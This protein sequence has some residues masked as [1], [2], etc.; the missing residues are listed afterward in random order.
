[1]LICQILHLHWLGSILH[2]NPMGLVD[3]QQLGHRNLTSVCS[4]QTQL[5]LC[6]LCLV[7]PLSVDSNVISSKRLPWPFKNCILY[8]IVL[9][10][11]PLLRLDFSTQRYHLRTH[12]YFM[13]ILF[14]A[15]FFSEHDSI[16]IQC[17]LGP[18]YSMTSCRMDICC[19]IWIQGLSR[20]SWGLRLGHIRLGHLPDGEGILDPWWIS[21]DFAAM[22]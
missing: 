22:T 10:L 1:M 14:A 5:K 4:A 20:Y 21:L 16:K 8:K 19:W 13:F 7:S 2:L 3:R 12:H 6:S 9:P 18:Y 17:F 11:T 15:W